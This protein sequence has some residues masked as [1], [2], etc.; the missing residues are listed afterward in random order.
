[1]APEKPLAVTSLTL[2]HFRSHKIARVHVDERPVA[3]FGANGAGKT[4]ILEA[5]S[6]LSPGRGLRRAS[7][8]DMAR[9]PDPIGWQLNADVVSGGAAH[10]IRTWSET[11]RRGRSG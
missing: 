11:G 1:M 7:A 9:R 8:S 10:E 6:M 2:S 5:L 3:I 4:N